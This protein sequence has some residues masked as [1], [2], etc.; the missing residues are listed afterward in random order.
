MIKMRT[1]EWFKMFEEKFSLRLYPVRFTGKILE[2]GTELLE[3]T[4]RLAE[5]TG[6]ASGCG[7]GFGLEHIGTAQPPTRIVLPVSLFFTY[8][9]LLLG[10]RCPGIS[11]WFSFWPKWRLVTL[12]TTQNCGLSTVM[13]GNPSFYACLSL[14]RQCFSP[15]PARIS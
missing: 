15:M 11:R 3:T 13:S 12:G 7:P 2:Y 5:V 10:P 1:Y 6:E 9:L 4:P 8:M 14:S